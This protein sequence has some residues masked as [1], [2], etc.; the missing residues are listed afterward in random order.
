MEVHVDTSALDVEDKENIMISREDLGNFLNHLVPDAKYSF[1]PEGSRDFDRIEQHFV[2]KKVKQLEKQKVYELQLV[3]E[4]EVI[5]EKEVDVEVEVEIG[6]LEDVR[7]SGTADMGNENPL[8][9]MGGWVIDWKA[10]NKV[11]C[12]SL[13]ELMKLDKKV[14][15]AALQ[16]KQVQERNLEKARDLSIVASYQIELKS[17]AN[18]SFSD[19]IDSLVQKSKELEKI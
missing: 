8:I 18:L 15:E 5:V 2:K 17:N 6:K 16:A 1:W 9:V 12:P 19:Y 11:S 14:V 10:S 13:D 7:V 3:H 4:A